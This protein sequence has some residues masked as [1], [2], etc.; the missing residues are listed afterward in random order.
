MYGRSIWVHSVICSMGWLGTAAA[1]DAQVVEHSGYP[2]CIELRNEHTRVIVCPACGGRVLEY[3]LDGKNALYLDPRQNGW[4]WEPGQAPTNPYGGRLDIGPEK[5][6]PKHPALW[7]GRWQSEIIGSRNVRLTSQEDEATGV[8][9]VRE[10]RLDEDSSKLTCTQIIRNVSDETKHWCHWSRTLA[11]GGGIALVPLEGFSRFPNKYIM[12]EPKS[13]IDYAPRD[14]NIRLRDCFLQILG[15]PR[16][17]KLGMDSYAGW[18][19]YLT[20]NDLMFVKRFPT[21]PNRVY[22]E[23]AAITISIW[24]FKDIMC[25]L[26]P[27]GPMET[28]APGQSASFTET[29]WLLPHEFPRDRTQV[30]T[31]QIADMVRRH[32]DGSPN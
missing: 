2:D 16:Q 13:L 11:R 1:L 27:I 26:E 23:V 4:I 10:F 19:C 29:W 6:V 22:N 7:L 18:L 9:L 28:I 30:N 32:T 15:T 3:S 5:I 21:Y 31:G 12:Y 14:P 25:E 20:T 8:Q 17:P 24:Y